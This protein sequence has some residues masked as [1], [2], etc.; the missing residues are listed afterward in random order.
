LVEPL[1]H[2]GRRDAQFF[3]DRR[4]Y[5]RGLFDER[6]EQVL[7]LELGVVPLLGVTLRAG[8]CLLRL[9]GQLVRVHVV[10][11]L[12]AWAWF[13]AEA[14]LR[15]C[16]SVC[17][18]LMRSSSSRMWSVRR[19]MTSTPARLTPISSVSRRIC[20]TRSRSCSEYRRM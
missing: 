17:K 4:R 13:R 16:T 14:A 3:Q 10:V 1:C 15:R 12:W 5:P 19:M 9:F 8:N 11:P 7:G 18:S 2:L 20:R 6:T